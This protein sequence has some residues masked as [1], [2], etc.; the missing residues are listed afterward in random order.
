[1]HSRGLAILEYVMTEEQSCSKEMISAI[2]LYSF[3]SSMMLLINKIVFTLVPLHSGVTAVQLIFCAGVVFGMQ[4]MGWI[5]VDN[6]EWEKV[7]P[8]LYY[9]LGFCLSIYANARALSDGTRPVRASALT[10]L[11][12]SEC[13]DG[14]RLSCLHSRCCLHI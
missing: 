5:D 2:A 12:C 6:F 9:V 1:M 8:Y 4:G 10:P 7:K 13:R 14:H 11:L 3:A